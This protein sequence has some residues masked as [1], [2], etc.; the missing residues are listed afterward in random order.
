VKKIHGGATAGGADQDDE[1]RLRTLAPTRT[2]AWSRL[3]SRND[4]VDLA[5]AYPGVSHAAAWADSG[6][7]ELVFLRAGT[8]GPR[9]PTPDEIGALADYL[10]ARRDTTFGLMVGAAAVTEVAASVQ[11]A[12]DPTRDPTA[13]VAAAAAALADPFGPLDP[14]ARSL[15]QPL[16]PSEL[17][18]VLHGVAGVLGVVALS[19]DGAAADALVPRPARR[20]ELLVLSQPVTVTRAAA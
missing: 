6:V 18:A 8:D 3:V 7:V 10:A 16:D 9:E 11:L 14:S 15:G 20:D 1:L 5:L 13:V 2:R 17:Y 12:L 19:L 4:A